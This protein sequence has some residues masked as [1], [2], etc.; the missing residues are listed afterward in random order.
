M[1][2]VGISPTGIQGPRGNG[3]LSGSGAPADILGVDG[4]WYVNNANPNAPVYYGPKTS[5]TWTGHGP[6]TFAVGGLSSITAADTSIVMGGTASAPTVRTNTLDVIAGQ[7]PPAAD[8]SNNGHKIT[9]VANGSAASDVAAFGQIP[10]SLPPSGTA[11]GDLS[12]TYP[13]PAVAKVNGTT[14]PATPTAGQVLVATSSTA[15]AWLGADLGA[16]IFNVQAYGAKGDGQLVTDGAMTAASAVLTSASGRFAAGDVGKLVL[17]KGAGPAG[18]TTLVTT[19]SAYTSATQVTLTA[20]ASTTVSSALVMWASDDTAAFQSAINAAVTWA[21]AHGSAARVFVPPASGQFYGIGGT[22]QTGGSTKGNAQL[23]LPVIAATANKVILTVEGA[24]DGAGL[25]HWQQ[26][27]P[28]CSGSTLVSF[29]VF[30]S[31][32][33]Q[34]ASINAAGN[35]CVIGGPS[36]PGGYGVSPGVFSNMHVTLRNLSILTTHSANGLTYS[37]VDLSGLANAAIENFAYGT[38]GTVAGNDYAAP[39][40]FANG[41][42]PG[43]LMPANGNNDLVLIRNVTC[44]GGYTY[45]AFVTEHAD[46]YGMRILYC[47]AAFCPVGTYYNSVGSTHAIV[48]TL[49]SIE[50]CTY[51]VY[52]IGSGSGGVGPFLHLRIDTETG[53]PRFGDNNSGAASAAA[54][55]DVVLTGLYTAAS[56]TLDNPVGYDIRDGQRSYPNIAVSANYTVTAFDELVTV[57]ATAAARTV[58][59]PTAVGRNRRIVVAKTDS[60]ANTV[61]IATTGGQTINGAAT[62]VLSAQWA[63]AELLPTAGGQ[64]IAR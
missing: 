7:H 1:P 33:A 35:A 43:L 2:N 60:S 59:L 3:W 51:L 16:W 31:S 17:V 45:G 6:Y 57:D 53:T 11:S 52:I 44:H 47:W 23:T 8:W 32:A 46:V 58:T 56:I 22:L 62:K 21:Q 36:Q 13:S 34:T 19:I 37:S 30:S 61:T 41:L 64:W 50:A 39:G 20:T 15:A 18:V 12:G 24:V 27:V 26:T 4:D 55:G 14:V 29:G 25:Q 54:R 9:G 42:V 48:A 5:G 10:T 63:T 28:Q 40:Q 49:L 38:T